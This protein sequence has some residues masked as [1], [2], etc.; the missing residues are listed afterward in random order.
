MTRVATH[1][2]DNPNRFK[3][4]KKRCSTCPFS[5]NQTTVEA[6]RLVE[7]KK[8]LR[9]TNRPFVCH[10]AMEYDLVCRGYFDT[11]SNLIVVLARMLGI[12]EF[13]TLEEAEIMGRC[14]GHMRHWFTDA[15]GHYRPDCRRCHAPNPRCPTK[16]ALP[17]VE[18]AYEEAVLRGSGTTTKIVPW[19][20]VPC[21]RKTA[22]R[23]YCPRHGPTNTYKA[24]AT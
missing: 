17:T 16:I 20:W 19:R 9:R 23:G 22:E 11:E 2:V 24:E 13:M 15:P 18:A 14:M 5:K 6:D 8:S 21:G 7:I 12:T 3:V 4:L 10:D 1:K